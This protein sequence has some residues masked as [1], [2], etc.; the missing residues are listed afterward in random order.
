MEVNEVIQV[1]LSIAEDD[2]VELT[3]DTATIIVIDDDGK[4]IASLHIY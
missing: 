3:A 1:K 4:L 2:S